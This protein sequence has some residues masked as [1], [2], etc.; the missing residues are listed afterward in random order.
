MNKADILSDLVLGNEIAEYD[1]NLYKYYVTTNATKDFVNDRYDI[2]RGSKGSGKSAMLIAVQQNQDCFS[3]LDGI[4]LVPVITLKGDPEYNKAFSG[5]SPDNTEVDELRNAWKI[6]FINTIW[7]NSCETLEKDRDNIKKLLEDN[8]LLTKDK[9]VL[10]ML[11]YAIARGRLRFY[12]GQPDGTECGFELSRAES[13]NNEVSDNYI[14]FNSIL[15]E[16]DNWLEA[17]GKKIWI[18]LDRLDDAFPD[19]KPTDKMILKSLLLAYKDICS[20]DN[21][22]M[23]IFIRD[24]IFDMVKDKGF[25]SLTHVNAKM[26]PSLRWEKDSI[27]KLL[28]ERLLHNQSFVE[29][30]DSMGLKTDCDAMTPDERRLIINKIMSEQID[31]GKSNPD[32]VGWII[33]HI[34][35]GKD[36]FTPRDF[37]KVFDKARTAQLIRYSNGNDIETEYLISPAAIKSAWKQVSEDKLNA[38]LIAEYPKCESWVMRFM[39]HKAEHTAETLESILGTRWKSYSSKLIEIGFIEKIG[40]RYKIPYI[41]QPVLNIKQGKEELVAKKRKTKE[42]T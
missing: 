3:A 32:S 31:T 33:N 11:R 6:F 36:R 18:L 15:F 41:Y 14:D 29:W 9:S 4:K 1:K 38:E 16:M 2:I 13:A 20:F 7:K 40:K 25:T 39:N 28:V 19:K 26:M 5:V 8:N 42:Q 34:K 22:K 23:K 24:D 12:R 10:D 21:F 17:N 27:E 30:I 35:D 37:L